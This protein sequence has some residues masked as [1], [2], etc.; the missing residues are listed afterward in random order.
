MKHNNQQELLFDDV[1]G[2]EQ[3][4]EGKDELNIAEFPLATVSRVGKEGSQIVEFGDTIRDSHNGGFVER[5]LKIIS[6]ANNCLPTATDDEVILGLVQLSK[7]QGFQ[8]PRV[9]FSRY[10]LIKIL[11]WPDKGRSYQRIEESLNRW[12][13]LTLEYKNAWR[14]R[15]KNAWIDSNFH[16]LERV[17][18]H[19]P[20]DPNSP[21]ESFFV[22]NEVI[23]KSFGDGNLKNLN[24]AD[25]RNLNSSIAKRMLRLLD[26]RFI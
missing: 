12:L 24:F 21:D 3:Y 5:K 16:I 14:D 8:S 19:R 13:G 2:F 25:Y 18:L 15:E 11:G 9:Y 23:F 4:I 20:D 22:W 17:D 1:K 6:S 26:K 10:Q 7:L